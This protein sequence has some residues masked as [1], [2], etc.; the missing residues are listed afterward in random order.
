MVLPFISSLKKND[1][2]LILEARLLEEG[3][4]KHLMECAVLASRCVQQDGEERP[5]MKEVAEELRKMSK[6]LE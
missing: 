6:R 2:D 4:M 3:K 1:L 5:T